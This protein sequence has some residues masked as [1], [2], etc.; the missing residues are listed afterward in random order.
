MVKRSCLVAIFVFIFPLS[1]LACDGWSKSI[2]TKYATLCYTNEKDI[3]RFTKGIRKGISL[4]DDTA[5]KNPSE[6]GNKVDSI[7]DRVSGLLDMHPF[8]LHFNINVYQN[9][10]E[11]DSAYTRMTTLGVFGRIPI[12]FYSHKSRT[13]YISME[14]LSAGIL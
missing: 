3:D 6:T 8:D 4:F 1:A 10:K 2:N 7:V 9:Q 12:A 11:I 5:R 13:I 14:N